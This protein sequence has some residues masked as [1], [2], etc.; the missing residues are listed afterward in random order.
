MDLKINLRYFNFW[1]LDYLIDKNMKK[2]IIYFLIYTRNKCLVLHTWLKYKYA[3]FF[4]I[5][6]YFIST[7]SLNTLVTI[8]IIKQ[9]EKSSHSVNFNL[10][11]SC[12]VFSKYRLS[13]NQHSFSFYFSSLTCIHDCCFLFF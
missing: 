4:K 3:F 9:F 8:F 13:I 11:T 5:N 2:I 7:V 6:M 10:Y 1:S 12:N